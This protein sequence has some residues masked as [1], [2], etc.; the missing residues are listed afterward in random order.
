MLLNDEASRVAVK[1]ATESKQA[2]YT[3]TKRA[4]DEIKGKA[5]NEKLLRS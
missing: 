2:T 1:L 5:T 3:S 4:G